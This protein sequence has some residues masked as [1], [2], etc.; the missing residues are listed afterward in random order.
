LNSA[1]ATVINATKYFI[2]DAWHIT[3]SPAW[4]NWNSADWLSGFLGA[5][6]IIYACDQQISILNPKIHNAE[7]RQLIFSKRQNG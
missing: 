2:E 3:S 7:R 1:A 4:P 5:F 6:G